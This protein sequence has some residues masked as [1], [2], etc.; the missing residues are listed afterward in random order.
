MRCCCPGPQAPC[1]AI[2]GQATS[3]SPSTACSW[4]RRRGTTSTTS[5]ASRQRAWPR[6]RSTVS[7]P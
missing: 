2:A 1:G 4:Q 5:A 6:A 3:S 7:P